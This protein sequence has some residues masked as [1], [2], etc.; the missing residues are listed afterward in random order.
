MRMTPAFAEE[1]RRLIEA[2]RT[3]VLWSWPLDYYP[4]TTDA[5]RRVLERIAA[6]G[7]RQTFVRARVLLRQLDE[8][9]AS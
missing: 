7:D 4:A 3:R 2:N 6:R 8:E 1:L 9:P 5:M